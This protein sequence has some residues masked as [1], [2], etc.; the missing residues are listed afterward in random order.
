MRSIWLNPTFDRTVDRLSFNIQCKLKRQENVYPDVWMARVHCCW[1]P[2][3]VLESGSFGLEG[4]EHS[5]KQQLIP[6]FDL[7]GPLKKKK[8]NFKS[9]CFS[10]LSSQQETRD[11]KGRICQYCSEPRPVK[12]WYSS[13]LLDSCCEIGPSFCW[14]RSCRT[15]NKRNWQSDFPSVRCCCR[16]LPSTW[17]SSIILFVLS[18][19]WMNLTQFP[20]DRSTSFYAARRHHPLPSR[21]PAPLVGLICTR[22]SVHSTLSD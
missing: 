21:L 2:C 18:S 6:V 8:T 11:K 4:V 13:S 9:R 19:E 16:L 20:L 17:L 22:N 15:A 7:S 5:L 3:T 14:G 10:V 1:S 12:T